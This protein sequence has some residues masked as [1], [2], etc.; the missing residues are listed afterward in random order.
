MHTIRVWDFETTGLEP[1]SEV[2]EL[3]WCDIF[4]GGSD[5]WQIGAGGSALYSV[6]YIPAAARAVHHI[7][8]ADLAGR[9]SFDRAEMWLDAH[10]DGVKVVAAHNASFDGQFWGQ[11]DLP[12]IC[13]YKSALRL[14]PDAPSHGNA[15]LRYWLEDQGALSIEHPS[16]ADPPHRAGPDA[17]VTA[18]LLVAM[19]NL[20]SAAQMVAWT[21]EPRLMPRITF[22]KHKGAAWPDLP[23]DYLDWL[24]RSDMDDDVKWNAQREIDRRK[25]GVAA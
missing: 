19:L 25:T 24:M 18:H 14:F 23:R 9:P 2:V 6:G 3:G 16:L 8:L 15:A 22:G 4:N 17:Y 13:T 11:P 7:T 20:T 12:V 10:A 21:K 5:G 1:D